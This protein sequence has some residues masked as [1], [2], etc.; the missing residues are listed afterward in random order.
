MERIRTLNLA[1]VSEISSSHALI[2][3][4]NFLRAKNRVKIDL[5]VSP[6]KNL[7]TCGKG[8]HI[9]GASF[10]FQENN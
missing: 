6:C 5:S 10:L 2:S 3:C 9:N 1:K 7:H 8:V 4:L